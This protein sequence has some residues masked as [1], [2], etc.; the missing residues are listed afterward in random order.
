MDDETRERIDKFVLELP[1]EGWGNGDIEK[2]ASALTE[3][4]A[5]PE[6]RARSIFTWITRNITYDVVGKSVDLDISV[7]DHVLMSCLRWI[8]ISVTLARV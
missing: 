6:E 7:E 5:A 3:H 2:L 1:D 4:F 8:K